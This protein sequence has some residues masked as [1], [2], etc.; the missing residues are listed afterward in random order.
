MK[1]T[2]PRIM[3]DTFHKCQAFLLQQL[4]MIPL[5]GSEQLA[6]CPVMDI[7]MAFLPPSFA[8]TENGQL[9]GLYHLVHMQGCRRIN[10]RVGTA[11]LQGVCVFKLGVLARYL[12]R[13]PSQVAVP[14]AAWLTSSLSQDTSHFPLGS[15]AATVTDATFCSTEV[16]ICPSPLR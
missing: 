3:P 8:L 4:Q 9:C 15:S 14:P 5:H 12:P 1:D 2:R 13:R 16:S 10:P 6:Q 7:P 11:G